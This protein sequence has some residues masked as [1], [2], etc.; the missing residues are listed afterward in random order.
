MLIYTLI[1]T[2]QLGTS[3][4]GEVESKIFLY[5]DATARS[6]KFFLD[7]TPEKN[8]ERRMDAK[9]SG[10]LHSSVIRDVKDIIHCLGGIKVLFPIFAQLD[11]P[12]APESPNEPI[13][14]NIDKYILQQSLALLFDMLH[15]S[16]T[17]VLEMVRSQG[18]SPS[19]LLHI[20]IIIIIIII[21]LIIL[22]IRY[23]NKIYYGD[24]NNDDNDDDD[25]N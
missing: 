6:G 13:D 24:N 21:L 8:R 3:C 15:K 16:E 19:S 5:Y 14:Y 11:Q 25:D 12:L 23:K 22:I 20:F 4:F 17:N 2:L 1:I 18:I 7:L 10:N 9:G